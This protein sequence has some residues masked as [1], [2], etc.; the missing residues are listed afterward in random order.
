MQR[1]CVC[2]RPTRGRIAGAELRGCNRPAPY[3][4]NKLYDDDYDVVGA[5]RQIKSARTGTRGCVRGAESD[6]VAYATAPKSAKRT[7]CL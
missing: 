4:Y 1:L 6:S 3:K 5:R 7:F 2:R